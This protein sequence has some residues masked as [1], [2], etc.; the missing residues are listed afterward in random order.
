MVGF[1][2]SNIV[3]CSAKEKDIR[4]G[5]IHVHKKLTVGSTCFSEP[6]LIVS[7]PLQ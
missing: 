6:C 2:G 7:L 3:K 1:W 5:M 4:R